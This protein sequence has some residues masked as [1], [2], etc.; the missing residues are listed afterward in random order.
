MKCIELPIDGGV[1][2]SGQ[3]FDFALSLTP[4]PMARDFIYLTAVVDWASRR[5]LAH[6]VAI[7]LEAEHAVAALEEAFAKYGQP[8]IVNTDQGSRFSDE[9]FTIC[10]SSFRSRPIFSQ[11]PV[12]YPE[13]HVFLWGFVTSQREASMN[14]LSLIDIA[15]M[16]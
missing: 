11:G 9:A 10:G 13:I 2:P 5:V 6:R 12:G 8:E 3:K 1:R 4:L 14:S 7:T 15:E 16:L